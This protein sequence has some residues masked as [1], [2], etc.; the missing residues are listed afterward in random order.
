MKNGMRTSNQPR[1]SQVARHVVVPDGIVS[2]G[3]PAVRDTL[4]NLGI[5]FDRWQ[6]DLA[7]VALGK[8]RDGKYAATVGGVVLSI[9][10]QVGKTFWA[11]SVIFA[12]YCSA[13]WSSLKPTKIMNIAFALGWPFLR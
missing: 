7:K 5:S 4:S 9:P 12:T 13:S 1:L 11:G 8:R 3:W 10:R 6:Q 2:T